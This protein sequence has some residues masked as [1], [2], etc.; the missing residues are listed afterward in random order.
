MAKTK[1]AP[2]PKDEHEPQERERRPFN[3][4]LDRAILKQAQIKCLTDEVRM[5]DVLEQF[6]DKWVRGVIDFEPNNKH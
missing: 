1:V 3:T 6:L 5:N 4:N 2:K